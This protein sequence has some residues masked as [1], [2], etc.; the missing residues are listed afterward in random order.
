MTG[1]PWAAAL[2]DAT[3]ALLK[4]AVA[5]R[6][7]ATTRLEEAYRAAQTVCEHPHVSEAVVS[8]G[9]RPARICEDCGLEEHHG[10]G[11]FHVL[12][13]DDVTR[14]EDPAALWQL[15]PV[16]GRTLVSWCPGNRFYPG[17]P[18]I[19]ERD[20]AEPVEGRCCVVHSLRYARDVL[21]ETDEAGGRRR[22]NGED[23]AAALARYEAAHPVRVAEGP[24][25]RQPRARTARW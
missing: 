8:D 13:G 10:A 14:L 24:R 9:W 12:A 3:A 18:V 4:A 11:G 1:Q 2:P 16:V 22:W 25:S 21:A 19:Y 23:I 7:L 5:D 17:H 15:R 20:G 6:E